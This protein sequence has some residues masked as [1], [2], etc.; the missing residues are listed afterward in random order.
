MA[1]KPKNHLIISPHSGPK[2]RKSKTLPFILLEVIYV[3]YLLQLKPLNIYLI[4]LILIKKSVTH[5]RAEED[6]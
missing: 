3:V 4:R 5:L 1:Y 2:Y 6:T